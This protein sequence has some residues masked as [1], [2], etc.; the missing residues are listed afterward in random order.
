MDGRLITEQDIKESNTNTCIYVLSRQA[1]EGIDRRAEKGDMFVIDIEEAN[2][3]S[4]C[5]IQSRF[6]EWRGCEQ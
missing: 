2:R 5:M 3:E 4:E 1:G 6:C